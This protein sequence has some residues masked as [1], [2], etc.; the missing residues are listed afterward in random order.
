MSKFTWLI[1]I[2][3]FG[4]RPSSLSAA[5]LTAPALI[6]RAKNFYAKSEYQAALQAALQALR[7]CED[8]ADTPVL[9]KA[10]GHETL[11]DIYE[12]LGLYHDSEQHY[13][14][15]LKLRTTTQGKEHPDVA[16]ILSS[17]AELKETMGLY[18]EAEKLYLQ[19]LPILSGKE[20]LRQNLQ[21]L[22]ANMA[23]LYKSMGYFEK[24]LNLNLQALEILK[25][26]VGL[27]HPQSAVVMDNIGV[28]YLAWGK[29]AEAKSYL[30]RARDILQKVEGE[31]HIDTIKAVH[32]LARYY[33]D[34][35]ELDQA[36]ALEER[37]LAGYKTK[38]GPRHPE[39]A[40]ALSNLANTN[41]L[42]GE[43]KTAEAQL[44]EALQIREEAL[45]PNNPDTMLALNDL[46]IVRMAAREPVPAVALLRR[47]LAV[48][49]L[50]LGRLRQI[51]VSGAITEFLASLHEQSHE[52]YTIA[53]NS[54]SPTGSR[55]AMATAM[56]RKGRS[57]DVVADTTRAILENLNPAARE[58]YHLLVLLR[59]ELSALL[60]KGLGSLKQADY[61][62]QVNRREAEI[63][64][65][66][67]ELS[68]LSPHFGEAQQKMDPETIVDQVASRLPPA[69]ALIEIVHY[70]PYRF[71]ARRQDAKWEA[72]RY[73]AMVLLPDNHRT[74]QLI[75]LGAAGA[76]EA[77]LRQYLRAVSQPPAEGCAGGASVTEL[78][79]T[80]YRKVMAPLQQ[81]LAGRRH[82]FL[83]LDG[84]LQLIPF[85]ALHDEDDY[86]LGRYHFNYLNSSRDLLGYIEPSKPHTTAMVFAD[87][88]LDQLPAGGGSPAAK[89]AQPT[90]LAQASVRATR[91]LCLGGL[92][93]LTGT[94]QEAQRIRYLLPGASLFLDASASE[95]N[96]L[97]AESPGILHVAGHSVT[98]DGQGEC[99]ADG[100]TQR[101][102]ESITVPPLNA[103]RHQVGLVL[104]GARALRRGGDHGLGTGSADGILTALEVTS[105][106]LWGTQLVVLSTC[107]SGRG[108][109]V[110]GEGVFGLRRA[111]MIA[112]AQTLVGSLWQ[113]H[114]YSAR[115]LITIYYERLLQG[116]DR[117]AAMD[118][119]ALA[120]K[121]KFGSPYYWAPFI[122]IGHSGKLEGFPT[123]PGT[124]VHPHHGPQRSR[125]WYA[126][127]VLLLLGV[128]AAV[129][130]KT[131]KSV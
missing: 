51:V 93:R 111:F 88:D 67:E 27:D 40:N 41:R 69:S 63:D 100:K 87:P 56:L 42:R 20:Q 16:N 46:A 5:E 125:L 119:A 103:P 62:Q 122:V 12:E 59:S 21:S 24:A 112:G 120:V 128:S 113:L 22:L 3:L 82:I 105:M 101:G 52:I 44:I 60:L 31:A 25:S 129:L 121:Q 1:L 13:L 84:D 65:L 92:E 18:D 77:D 68:T 73:L 7:L 32:N 108:A 11:A 10:D 64:Q 124:S 53:E 30:L 70:R 2:L 86:L 61:Q 37:A 117:V 81:A 19:A 96:L 14:A 85:A 29:P 72:P 83:S 45:G 102:L 36:L 58:K 71:G 114:D 49:E 39:I 97:A 94:R 15:G 48:S 6:E 43:Y 74:V 116:A 131:P 8:R 17:L 127:A 126:I 106:N 79:R 110:S 123:R 78:A 89:P 98:L 23:V 35:G 26:T 55:L 50:V 75:P 38:Y 76:L 80:V 95:E 104:A 107:D 34:I 130:R 54:P 47:S 66:T 99:T 28:L 9:L 57:L 4:C 115:D 91:G 33:R 118:D 109:V 90:L